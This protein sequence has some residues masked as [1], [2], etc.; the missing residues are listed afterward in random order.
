M[1]ELDLG[2]KVGVRGL[3]WSMGY[4]TRLDVQLR[5][6]AVHGARTAPESFTDLDVLGVLVGPAHDLRSTIADCKSGTRDKPTSRMFWARGV[7]DFFGADHA[8]LVR[9]HEVNDATRQLSSRLNISVLSTADLAAMQQLHGAPLDDPSGP[10]SVLF[11]KVTVAAAL[12]A[13]TG[14]D[15]KLR[16]LLE[17]REFDYWLYDPRDNPI[18]MVAHLREARNKLDAKNPVHLA[19]FLD[20]AWLHLVSLIRVASYVQGAFLRDVD[21]GLQEYMLGGATGVREKR[22]M[23]EM[24]E[25]MKPEGTPPLDYLPEYYGNLRELV[26][27]LLRR[28]GEMQTALRYAEAASALMAARQRVPLDAAFGPGFDPVAAKLVADVCG[29]LVAAAGLDPRFRAE[30]RAFLLAEGVS[31]PTP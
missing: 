24:F 31:A 4:S 23:A 26:T 7:A 22:K 14:L 11:D 2:L 12:K 13:F 20:L 5:G 29:F 3:L 10:L 1:S 16:S 25:R 15:R 21:R 30:A 8:M 9:E 28:P 19:L 6:E 17:Y 18:Q 27:R